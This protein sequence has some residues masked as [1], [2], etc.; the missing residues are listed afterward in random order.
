MLLTQKSEKSSVSS[1]FSVL[2][3]QFS[4]LSSQFSVLSSQF[5]VLSSQFSVLS[6]QFSVLSSLGEEYTDNKY[7]IVENL[8]RHR[9]LLLSAGSCAFFVLNNF[10]YKERF[11]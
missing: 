1:Q 7:T 10:F 5:S 11:L 3:S 6:S 2:S 9:F 4:V 8:K